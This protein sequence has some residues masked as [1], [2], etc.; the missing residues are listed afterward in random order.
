VAIEFAASCR[1]LRKS[2]NSATAI[3]AISSGRA[4]AISFIGAFPRN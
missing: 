3:K 2:N 1:P 4:S